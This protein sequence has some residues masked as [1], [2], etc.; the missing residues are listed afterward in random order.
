MKIIEFEP[1]NEKMIL[2]DDTLHKKKSNYEHIYQ[3]IDLKQHLYG[4]CRQFYCTG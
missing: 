4:L 3:I 1:K 2:E